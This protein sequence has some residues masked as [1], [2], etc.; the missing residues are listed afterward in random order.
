MMLGIAGCCR[1]L[2]GVPVLHGGPRGALSDC[3]CCRVLQSVAESCG[4]LQSVAAHYSLLHRVQVYYHE[5]ITR[6]RVLARVAAF[7]TVLQR[8]AVG[9][10]GYRGRAGMY[11]DPGS[12]DYFDNLYRFA[13]LS[14]AALE[15]EIPKKKKN[16][17]SQRVTEL[18]GHN[19]SSIYYAKS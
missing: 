3:I 4:V 8:V 6:A 2:Q 16:D 1:M 18:T 15:V 13:V 11:G 14:W 10:Q 12:H 17:K 9:N 19:G 7:C 5:C